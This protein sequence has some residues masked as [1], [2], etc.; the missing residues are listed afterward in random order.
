[1]LAHSAACT[2]GARLTP[3]ARGRTPEVDVNDDVNDNENA[4]A[5]ETPDE[6]GQTTHESGEQ[7]GGGE[8]HAGAEGGPEGQ[9]PEQ[10][11]EPAVAPQSTAEAPPAETPPAETPPAETPP[12]ETPTA[13]APTAEVPTQPSAAEQVGAEPGTKAAADQATAN[14]T[15]TAAASADP[16]AEAAGSEPGA[17]VDPEALEQA[18]ERIVKALSKEHSLKPE[19]VEAVLGHLDRGLCAPVVGRVHR[20][21][22]GAVHEAVVRKLAQRRA[23]LEELDRRRAKIVDAIRAAGPEHAGLLSVATTRTDRAELEDLLLPLRNPEPE[24]QLALDRGL[25]ELAAR[26]VARVDRP[27]DAPKVGEGLG[28]ETPAAEAMQT[29]TRTETSPT[30]E[31]PASAGAETA[32][33]TAEQ[34]ASDAPSPESSTSEAPAPEPAPE[35][36]ATVEAAQVEPTP[37]ES[38]AAETTD[39]PTPAA[40]APPVDAPT[41]PAPVEAAAAAPSAPSPSPASPAPSP[42]P[43]PQV[44][45]VV[46][47]NQELSRVC[48]EFV[49]P[50]RDV[51]TEMQAL[52][53]AMRI[54]S[55]RLGRSPKVRRTV[56]DVLRKQGLVH[57]YP[58]TNEGRSGRYKALFSKPHPVRN[59]QGQKL[60]SLRQ[61]LKE[62][63]LS[64]VVRVDPGKI[65]P[66]VRRE[67]ASTNAPEFDGVL[68]E[69]ARR[70]L[71]RRLLPMIEEDVR[72]EVKEHAEEEAKRN[73]TAQLRHTLLAPMLGPRTAAGIEVDAKG[74]WTIAIVDE[75]GGVIE[76]DKKVETG[77]KDLHDVASALADVMRPS[78]ARWIAMSPAK[79]A[80]PALLKVRE[81]VRLLG[82][83]ATVTIVGDGGLSAYANGEP[84]RQELPELSVQARTAVSLARRLQDP[85]A[86][87]LKLDSRH[88]GLGFEQ[89]LLTKAALRRLIEDT[90]ESCVTAVGVTFPD[91]TVEQLARIPGIDAELAAKLVAARDQGAIESRA[92]LA[93]IGLLDE[94]QYAN[95]V[96]FL[97]FP[98]SPEPLDRSALHPDQYELARSVLAATGRPAGDVYGRAGAGKGLDRSAF[99]VDEFTWRD[100]LR[101]LSFPGRDLRPRLHPLQLLP[102]DTDP[103]SIDRDTVLE[104]IVTGVTN[105][106]AFVDIGLEREASLHV[107]AISDRFLRD[108]REHLSVGQMVRVKLAEAKGPRLAVTMRAVPARERHRG[109]RGEG[110]R[111]PRRGGGRGQ[112]RESGWTKPQKNARVA[113]HRR[114]G[115]PGLEGGGRRGGPGGGFPS[116]RGGPGGG[117]RGGRGRDREDVGH[118]PVPKSGVPSSGYNNPLKDFFKKRD[119]DDEGPAE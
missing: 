20:A 33:A 100:L 110:G 10:Q 21:S 104:G 7:H 16:K 83:D 5:P 12:A 43:A 112:Q 103:A 101:E 93:H 52:E 98:G 54:L 64:V 69:I 73:L 67:L 70:A 68:D 23:E 113:S 63:A 4:H 88:F 106:G 99:G 22:T 55:D 50:D 62:R 76:P 29:A 66:R 11:P 24:V 47:L 61:G 65:L 38:A 32:S 49:R 58:G 59:L 13:E 26:L 6:S 82:I 40:T 84:G 89:S 57:V 81:A 31:S 60:I 86:E 25:G 3:A 118:G 19:A 72:L 96:A 37:T 2:R 71:E 28:R 9:A 109:P 44:E 92:Q 36:S 117:R 94:V 116:K 87:I 85:M 79:S 45:R 78:N 115:V 95:A 46:A 27:A 1:M 91:A 77:D 48:S 75:S 90:I 80:R 18:R 35:S 102:A 56:R 14:G 30:T 97:R 8:H 119:G 42:A 53:G 34:A 74:D 111:G 39:A 15:A 51:H 107:S 108:A 17:A 105:F 41:A 114:D